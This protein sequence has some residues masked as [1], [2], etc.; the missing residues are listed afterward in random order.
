MIVGIKKGGK[1]DQEPYRAKE[2]ER[3]RKEKSKDH[4]KEHS[5]AD[6]ESDLSDQ[7]T[8][9]ADTKKF[10]SKGVIIWHTGPVYPPVVFVGCLSFEGFLKGIKISSVVAGSDKGLKIGSG[11]ENDN[12]GND[13]ERQE[14]EFVV[15]L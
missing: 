8:L 15:F 9:N 11:E 7:N 2:S 13:N 3:G 1:K 10:I 12:A 6:L 5:G 14:K 4:I